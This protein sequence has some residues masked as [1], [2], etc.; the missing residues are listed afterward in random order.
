MRSE[1][2]P[3]VQAPSSPP[4][5]PPAAAQAA[6]PATQ[7]P[8]KKRSRLRGPVSNRIKTFDDEFDVDSI[9]T[10]VADDDEP[11]QDV[12]SQSQNGVA[13]SRY[14]SVPPIKEDRRQDR[15]TSVK[16]SRRT[17]ESEEDMVNELLP[18]ATAMKRRNLEMEG[19]SGAGRVSREK[20]TPLPVI[21][22]KKRKKEIDVREAARKQREAEEEAERRERE[23]DEQGYEEI[24]LV[25]PA[26]LVTVEEMP[27]RV[28][29]DRPSRAS[30]DGGIGNDRWDE[31]WNG[32]KNFKK[33][34]RKGDPSGGPRR[35]V[36][37]VIVP[38]VEVKKHSY[39]IGEQ[40]WDHG[41]D[42]ESGSKRKK[43][44]ASQGQ[45]LTQS[46]PRLRD[47]LQTL[48]QTQTGDEDHEER[49]S[50]T[51]T[52]LQ[53]EA[54]EIV[55]AIDMDSPR[56]TRL[57][58]K[59]QSQNARP[60]KRPAFSAGAGATKKQKTIQTRPA[61]DDSDSDDLKFRFGRRIKR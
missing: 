21:K 39:G 2:T 54:A 58:D 28:R 43:R 60:K 35:V 26:N 38:L 41:S 25:K 33:F 59:A 27:L 4:D 23:R 53:Q 9:P 10:F 46:Q 22:P 5:T 61:S 34:R 48:T 37:N 13:N 7:E 17:S 12:A 40:Y 47:Q 6:P 30:E 49:T 15:R 20:A 42:E 29:A 18:A 55:G 36:Q 44:G 8:P 3:N 51:A 31:R 56:R 50:S 57:A 1:V 16:R 45:S 24:D 14:E 52:R 11:S 32:R 19:N